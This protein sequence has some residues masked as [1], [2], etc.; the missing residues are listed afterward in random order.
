MEIQLSFSAFEENRTLCTC[1]DL[2]LRLCALSDESRVRLA[3][4]MMERGG[5]SDIQSLEKA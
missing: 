4:W 1:H 3:S 5:V 2:N